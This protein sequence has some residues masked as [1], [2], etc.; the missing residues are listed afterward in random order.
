MLFR[1]LI[2]V[3]DDVLRAHPDL[4][5]QVFDAFAQS[6]RL[7]VED[8]KAGRITSPSPID[9]V[10]L[11]ALEVMTDP[12][13]YGIAP[14]AEVLDGLI[15][16]AVVQGIIPEAVPLEDLFAPVLRDRVG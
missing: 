7:Y 5:E 1:S 14:N 4:A 16:H 12:L 9:Q 3:R 2:V 13:P 11:A 15:N 10:H 8:L 6:K